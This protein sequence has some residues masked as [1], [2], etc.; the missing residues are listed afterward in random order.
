MWLIRLRRT[1]RLTHRRPGP[2]DVESCTWFSTWLAAW[3]WHR[4]RRPKS[5]TR[6]NFMCQIRFFAKKKIALYKYKIKFQV[7]N[8]T[9]PSWKSPI[10][11]VSSSSN[12][13]WTNQQSDSQV[14]A[15]FSCD[16]KQEVLQSRCTGNEDIWLVCFERNGPFPVSPFQICAIYLRSV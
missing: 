12:Y 4:L 13:N 9:D 15:G 16:K 7:L 11:F 3:E 10:L 14:E 2:C 5:W 8:L 1:P 6:L